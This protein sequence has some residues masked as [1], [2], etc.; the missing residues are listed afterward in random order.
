MPAHITYPQV[1]SHSAGFSSFWLQTILRGELGF[2]GV[3]FSDDL[4][5]EGASMAGDRKSVV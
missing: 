4:T 1:D 5:M 2:D 3:I